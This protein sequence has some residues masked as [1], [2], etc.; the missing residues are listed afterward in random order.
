MGVEHD[1]AIDLGVQAVNAYYDGDYDR[2]R[3]SYPWYQYTNEAVQAKVEALDPN[4]A[5]A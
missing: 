5:V 2:V 1:V 4:Q 3:S